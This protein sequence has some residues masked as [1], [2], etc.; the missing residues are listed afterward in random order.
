VPHLFELPTALLEYLDLLQVDCSPPA[1]Q[2]CYTYMIIKMIEVYITALI[3]A[4][5]TMDTTSKQLYCSPHLC[6]ILSI[7]LKEDTSLPT[8]FS[9]LFNSTNQQL[10][11]KNFCNQRSRT[12]DFR[13]KWKPSRAI[14]TFRG[15]KRWMRHK[16]GPW[17]VHEECIA[18]TK[19]L[20]IVELY[21]SEGIS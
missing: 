17:Y 5:E 9:P 20:A 16:E 8:M 13:N 1:P 6:I 12:D 4:G 7:S 15:E 18:C 3:I 19:A 11:K 21:E 14:D 10:F 2:G